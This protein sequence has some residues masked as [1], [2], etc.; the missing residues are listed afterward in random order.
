MEPMIVTNPNV[1][2]ACVDLKWQQLPDGRWRAF[3]T[4]DFNLALGYVSL[5]VPHSLTIEPGEVWYEP[6]AFENTESLWSEEMAEMLRQHDA[7]QEA[8]RRKYREY[9]W[10]GAGEPHRVYVGKLRAEALAELKAWGMAFKDGAKAEAILAEE[11]ILQGDARKLQKLLTDNA[12]KQRRA[13]DRVAASEPRGPQTCSDDVIETAIIALTGLD[14][15]KSTVPN[16]EGWGGSTTAV[17]HWCHAMLR[18]NRALAI[19]EGRRL[20]ALGKHEAQLARLGIDVGSA[21]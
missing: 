4:P 11:F 9:M 3:A 13:A 10:N 17:G 15:D 18:V 19:K 5:P 8:E 6:E 2:P 16:R 12:G 20:I 14:E 21:S 1:P 7:A